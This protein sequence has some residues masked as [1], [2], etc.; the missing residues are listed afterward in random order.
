MDVAR[1]PAP[2]RDAALAQPHSAGE[3]GM[4]LPS[5]S[6]LLNAPDSQPS[7]PS[8]HSPT[9]LPPFATFDAPPPTSHLAD[10]VSPATAESGSSASTSCRPI[11]PPSHYPAVASAS[12]DTASDAGIAYSHALPITRP[13]SPPPRHLTSLQ[14]PDGNALHPLPSGLSA[15]NR[16]PRAASVSHAAPFDRA[17]YSR[18]PGFATSSERR[19]AAHGHELSDARERYQD[20][21]AGAAYHFEATRPRAMSISSTEEYRAHLGW[22]GSSAQH[23]QHLAARPDV[24]PR[25]NTAQPAFSAPHYAYIPNRT[26]S[27]SP[28]SHP[29]VQHQPPSEGWPPQMMSSYPP[30]HP[31]HTAPSRRH[32]LHNLV[33]LSI[34]SGLPLTGPTSPP[35]PTQQYPPHSAGAA[36]PSA[37]AAAPLG[38]APGSQPSGATPAEPAQ[39]AGRYGCPHCPKRFARP[40]SL[41]IHMHSHTG[42]KPFTC[43][44]CD[45]AFSVQSNLRRHLKIHKGGNG[46][47]TASSAAVP[48]SAA[49]AASASDVRGL[50]GVEDGGTLPSPVG[51]SDGSSAAASTRSLGR[52]SSAD[53]VGSA[54]AGGTDGEADDHAIEEEDEAMAADPHGTRPVVV[55]GVPASG[56]P[57]V[58]TAWPRAGERSS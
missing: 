18:L 45:R 4:R 22:A 11:P 30:P 28:F 8:S 56:A 42:E 17:V 32:D 55:G 1:G 3:L 52:R 46:V 35:N 50:A 36:S 12:A 34:P 48:R 44:M 2:G 31:H 7:E 40:S 39:D 57:T 27:F 19:G 16:R 21:S 20:E 15:S 13:P 5:I 38:A 43:P 51:E 10:S 54:S 26:S 24:Q 9:R 14:F 47:P 53:R 58:R 23:E 37:W 41:R 25:P 49:S 33:P 29:P 6:I